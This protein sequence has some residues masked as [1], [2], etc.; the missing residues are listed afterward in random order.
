M[1][2]LKLKFRIDEEAEWRIRAVAR[3]SVKGGRLTLF[4]HPKRAFETIQLSRIKALSIQPVGE[5]A[6]PFPTCERSAGRLVFRK[7]PAS[8]SAV[9][10]GSLYR[11]C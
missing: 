8:G 9:E 1:T 6:V 11:V 4:A 5:A 3:L 2:G 7:N 10:R